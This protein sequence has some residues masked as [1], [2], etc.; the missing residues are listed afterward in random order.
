MQAMGLKPHLCV[1][2]HKAVELIG[3]RWTGAVI[4]LLLSGRMRFA[5]LRA[6]IPDI[7]DRMLSERLREL[8]AEGIVARMVVPETPVRVEYELT[9]K[10]RALEHAL[11]AVGKWAERWVTEPRSPRQPAATGRKRAAQR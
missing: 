1:R 6:A 3:G 9:E 4:N 5:E 7:S 10:G 2:F 11:A 8:E